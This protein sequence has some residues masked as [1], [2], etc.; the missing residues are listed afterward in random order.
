[1]SRTKKQV[2]VTIKGREVPV[3]Y[4]ARVGKILEQ[5][6]TDAPWPVLAAIVHHR[7]VDLGFPVTAPGEIVPVDYTMREGVLVYRRTTSLILYEAARQ[8]FPKV[9][10]SIGQALGNGYFYNVRTEEPFSEEDLARLQA[11]MNKL[12]EADLPMRTQK[13]SLQEAR[14]IFS[15][16]GHTDKLRLLDSWWEPFITLDRCGRFRDIHRYPVAPNTGHTRTFELVH[17]PPGMLLRFPPG[18]APTQCALSSPRPS[19]FR[20]TTRPASGTRS[21]APRTWGS[22]TSRPSRAPPMS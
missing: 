12:V 7:C 3:P 4:R 22:S 14:Q 18:G 5:H 19:S 9:R 21:S 16:Q 1:M 6:L 10:V 13:V 15:A 8:L 20:C 11:R 2:L 17:Y